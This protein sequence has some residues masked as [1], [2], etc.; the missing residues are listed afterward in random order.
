MIYFRSL[1]TVLTQGKCPDL[2]PCGWHEMFSD[3][4]ESFMSGLYISWLPTGHSRDFQKSNSTWEGLGAK[5]GVDRRVGGREGCEM[6][7]TVP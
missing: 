6:L 4:M 7:G 1:T 2:S 3:G 5:V